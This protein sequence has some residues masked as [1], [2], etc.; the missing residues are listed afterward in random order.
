MI[1]KEQK[2][3]T[4]SLGFLLTVTILVGDFEKEARHVTFEDYETKLVGP[5]APHRI[6]VQLGL[7]PKQ[8]NDAAAHE[9]FHLFYSIRHLI[10]ADEETQ[11]I[12]FGQLVSQIHECFE[13]ALT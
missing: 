7:T 6:E 5:D 1:T 12:V 4:D 13:N 9:A 10:T 2:I 3:A 11:A 8:L